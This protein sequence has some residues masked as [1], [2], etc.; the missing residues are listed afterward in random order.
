MNERIN[1]KTTVN[2][3]IIKLLCE[4][5]VMFEILYNFSSLVK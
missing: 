3:M 1:A 4:Y 2:A 5:L